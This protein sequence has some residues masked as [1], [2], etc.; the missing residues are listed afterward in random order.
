MI[1][2]KQK[3]ISRFLIDNDDR[4]LSSDK[5]KHT[6]MMSPWPDG[7]LMIGTY[8]NDGDV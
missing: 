5:H 4:K 3:G 1:L 7:R 6:R 8:K 2:Q